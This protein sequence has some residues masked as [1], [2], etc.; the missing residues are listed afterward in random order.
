[1]NGVMRDVLI[2]LCW[3]TPAWPTKAKAE[4][5]GTPYLCILPGSHYHV[6]VSR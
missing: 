1:M 2:Y 6:E 5:H 4:K 3:R